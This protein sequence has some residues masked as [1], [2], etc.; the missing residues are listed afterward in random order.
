MLFLAPAPTGSAPICLACSAVSGCEE[1]AAAPFADMAGRNSE[2]GLAARR[3][4]WEAARPSEPGELASE[5]GC[6]RGSEAHRSKA[7]WM[8]P[9][10]VGRG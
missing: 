6:E 8:G 9:G 3:G 1:E 5:R 10:S 4:D 7:A 2:R